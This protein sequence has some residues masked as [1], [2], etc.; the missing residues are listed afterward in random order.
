MRFARLQQV[1][2]LARS[3]VRL[4]AREALGGICASSRRSSASFAAALV[5]DVQRKLGRSRHDYPPDDKLRI[6]G[7]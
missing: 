5:D 2:D 3:Q 4:R 6:G 1:P 7:R